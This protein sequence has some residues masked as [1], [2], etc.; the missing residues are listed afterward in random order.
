MKEIEQGAD[1][2]STLTAV[3]LLTPQEC[4]AITGSISPETRA[5]TLRELAKWKLQGLAARRDDRLRIL[6][7]LVTLFFAVFVLTVG[8][9]M[10]GFLSQLV[11]SLAQVI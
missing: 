4:T 6:Q 11:Q 7:P 1:A 5:W 9:A 8:V 10:I 3:N 2:W